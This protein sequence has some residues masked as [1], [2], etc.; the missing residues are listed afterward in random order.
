MPICE[1]ICKDCKNKFEVVQVKK[2]DKPRS[3]P[4]CKSLKLFKIE[5]SKSTFVLKGKWHKTGGY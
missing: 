4:K 1:Y 3:C 2:C 5:I